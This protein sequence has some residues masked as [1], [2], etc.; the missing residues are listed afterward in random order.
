M[1]KQLIKSVK[2]LIDGKRHYNLQLLSTDLDYTLTVGEQ[3]TEAKLVDHASGTS[4]MIRIKLTDHNRFVLR[5][6]SATRQMKNIGEYCTAHRISPYMLLNEIFSPKSYY[7]KWNAPELYESFNK[8]FMKLGGWKRGI[9]V[10][11]YVDE[12]VVVVQVCNPYGNR[13]MDTIDMTKYSTP[14][15]T[16]A[17][18]LSLSLMHSERV[19]HITIDGSRS[20]CPLETITSRIKQAIELGVDVRCSNGDSTV[21][22]T[23][24]NGSVMINKRYTP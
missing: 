7:R 18:V 10:D 23:T 15:L 16:A 9:R 17:T 19:G 14:S 13:Y 3:L 22:F 11:H 8:W 6:I 24:A 1:I 12:N 2:D 5:W 20:Y 21:F 4:D